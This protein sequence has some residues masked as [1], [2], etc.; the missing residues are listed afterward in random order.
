MSDSVKVKR[1]TDWILNP[2]INPVT[3]TKLNVLSKN[4]IF[5]KYLRDTENNN[6]ASNRAIERIKIL[7]DE[8]K[9]REISYCIAW[10]KNKSRNP[11]TGRPIKLQSPGKKPPA[12]AN[13]MNKLCERIKNTYGGDY[14]HEY[15]KKFNHTLDIVKE[16][17]NVKDIPRSLANSPNKGKRLIVK[18]TN[19]KKKEPKAKK[20]PKPKKSTKKRNSKKEG[21]GG[22]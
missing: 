17:V 20:S 14:K 9:D 1:I 3:G 15:D 19:K 8:V 5:A 12:T 11:V 22:I 13:K 18:I 4:G 16:S 6:R 21:C 10:S 7:R 2:L